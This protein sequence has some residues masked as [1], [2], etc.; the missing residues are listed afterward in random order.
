[1]GKIKLLLNVIEDMRCLASSLEE[2]AKAFCD[3]EGV[4]DEAVYGSK[5]NKVDSWE[6]E[7]K[8]IEEKGE[9]IKDK[10]KVVDEKDKAREDKTFKEEDEEKLDRNFRKG[11]ERKSDNLGREISL[12]EVRA[13]LAKRSREGFTD[14]IREIIKSYNCNKLSE[15]KPEYYEEVMKRAEEFSDDER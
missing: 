13:F 6:K 12:E 15:I 11:D 9:R 14:K 7:D 10:Y 1:M 2:V 5:L 4:N 8:K 3:K